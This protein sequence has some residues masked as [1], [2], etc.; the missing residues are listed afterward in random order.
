[1]GAGISSTARRDDGGSLSPSRP[2]LGDIPE[3]C[4]SSLLMN[5]DPPDICQLAR[6]NR[7]F[8][9]ASSADFVW[10]SKLPPSY[11]FLANKV[12]GEESI[13]AMTKKDIYTK[14]C[15]PNRFDG[16]TIVSYIILMLISVFLIN[17][18]LIS[19]S[20]FQLLTTLFDLILSGDYYRKF[21]WI[22]AVDK[23]VCSCHRNP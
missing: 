1:M 13:A 10:E 9:R 4:I 21:G 12:L 22:N 23:F 6:V 7:A 8:H 17:F 19:F 14:L 5:L 16:G 18:L 3:S 15:L 20:S 2:G 11:K